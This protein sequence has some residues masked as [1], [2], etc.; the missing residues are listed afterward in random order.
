[1]LMSQVLMPEHAATPG[2]TDLAA[3]RVALRG[4][5]LNPDDREYGTATAAWCAGVRQAPSLIILPETAA[6]V[7][8]A[9]GFARDHGL[10]VA[11][12]AT[13]HGAAKPCDHG[14][15]INTSRMQ[16]VTIDPVARTARVE[17]GTKWSAVI[18]LAQEQRLAP[19][20]GS[21][22]DIGVV[23]YTLGG[24]TGWMARKYGF[25]ADRILGADIVTADGAALRI[26]GTEHEELLWAL[27]GGSGNFGIV[28]ALEFELVPVTTVYGGGVV[29]PLVQAPTVLPAFATWVETLPEEITASVAIMRLPPMPELPPMLRG[30][31][32]V[33][34]RACGLGDLTAAA[35]AIAPMR[36]LGTPLLDTFAVMPYTAIDSISMDPVDPMPIISATSLLEEL[37]PSAI[38]ALLAVA[39]P[40]VDSPV[41]MIELRYIAGASERSP[42]AGGNANRDTA[43]FTLYAI[44]V[45]GDP[46]GRGVVQASLKRVVTTLAPFASDKVFLNF[47]GDGDWGPERT[48]AAYTAD[49]YTRLQRI[50]AQVDPENRFCFNH[51]IQPEG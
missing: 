23:G 9:V 15:L 26:S 36:K 42:R 20:N 49:D 13:G 44:G 4:A 16:G 24:G 28:T 47:L 33:I 27:R 12:Q 8:T 34:V 50:K 39:G 30:Q 37:S 41:M 1:M 18:P 3:L 21:S 6:D 43:P 2:L 51:N 31:E 25:A 32:V 48:R 38:D 22:S 29:Y 5:V 17:A 10:P 45:A 46:E 11:V 19:L 14:L 35:T 40:G 7:A